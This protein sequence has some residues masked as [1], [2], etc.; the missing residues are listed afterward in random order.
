V[1]KA[2]GIAR[3]IPARRDAILSAARKV[4]LRDGYQASLDTIA[5]EAGVARRTV[6]YQFGSK[7]EL[8]REIVDAM[9]ADAAPTLALDGD[10]DIAANLQQFARAYVA[11]VTSPETLM[12]YRMIVF[13]APSLLAKM[14]ATVEHN[15]TRIAAQLAQY[16]KSQIAAGRMRDVNVDYA[17]EQFL[18]SILGFARIEIMLGIKPKMRRRADYVEATVQSFL[19]GVIKG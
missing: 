17:A 3:R 12:L 4:F 5:D 2:A 18:T 19:E 9:T 13:G 7:E 15:F 16:F 1:L 11:A 10:A 14:R 6:F 8:L